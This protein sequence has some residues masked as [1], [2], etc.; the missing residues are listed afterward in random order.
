MESVI[1]VAAAHINHYLPPNHADRRPVLH[2]F[3]RA[4]SN[5]QNALS[6]EI[7]SPDKTADAFDA[8]LGCSFLISQYC[9]TQIQDGPTRW[10]KVVNTFQHDVSLSQSLKSIVVACQDVATEGEWWK[11]LSYSPKANLERYIREEVNL[12]RDPFSDLFMHCLFC[13]QGTRDPEGASADNLNAA[14]RLGI[15]LTV[16][17][18]TLPNV[19]ASGY[20]S[21]ISRFLFTWPSFCTRGYMQQIKEGNMTALT[22][23]LCYYAAILRM[24]SGKTWFMR[25]RAMFMYSALREQ[26]EGKCARCLKPALVLYDGRA[27]DADL[28]LSREDIGLTDDL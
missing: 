12:K 11:I 17:Y 1:L 6:Q 8:I 13:G 2:Y 21:D 26:L 18:M 9:L 7:A 25:D 5:L 4:L 28:P 23:L 27:I 15:P 3:S 24:C 22:I 16:I 19:E 14:S 10:L 20:A